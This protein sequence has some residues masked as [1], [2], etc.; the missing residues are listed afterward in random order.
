MLIIRKIQD[1]AMELMKVGESIN[2]T[3]YM[4]TT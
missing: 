3:V 2:L 1:K 4:K